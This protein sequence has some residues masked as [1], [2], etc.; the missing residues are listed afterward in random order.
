MVD[1]CIEECAHPQR[2][3][4]RICISVNNLSNQDDKTQQAPQS[5]SRASIAAIKR[6][7]KPPGV[8]GAIFLPV[9]QPPPSL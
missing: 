2:R 1:K 7:P 6:F 8:S 5:L 4:F 9:R 3:A